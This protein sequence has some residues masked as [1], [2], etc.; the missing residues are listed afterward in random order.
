MPFSKN[1][2]HLGHVSHMGN[3]FAMQMRYSIGGIRCLVVPKELKGRR[4][5]PHSSGNAAQFNKIV[6]G[7]KP[8]HLKRFES[9]TKL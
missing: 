4:N 5:N 6:C 2:T 1:S 9:D 8:S 3:P 7:M